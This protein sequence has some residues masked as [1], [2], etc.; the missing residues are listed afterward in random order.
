MNVFVGFEVISLFYNNMCGMDIYYQVSHLLCLLT[1][2]IWKFWTKNEQINKKFKR[3]SITQ[4]CLCI[5]LN[6]H[7]SHFLLSKLNQ[8]NKHSQHRLRSDAFYLL[9]LGNRVCYNLTNGWRKYNKHMQ[10]MKRKYL[11]HPPT[12]KLHILI[13]LSCQQQRTTNWHNFVLIC[14]NH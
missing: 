5:Y 12:K 4:C 8:S 9:C 10:F 2:F 3:N 6:T 13:F 11:F 14:F 7:S 1:R